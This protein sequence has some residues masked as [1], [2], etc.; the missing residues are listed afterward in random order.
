MTL[1]RS[2]LKCIAFQE[3]MKEPFSGGTFTSKASPRVTANH[4]LRQ[5][6]SFPALPPPHSALPPPGSLP[7]HSP[8]LWSPGPGPLLPPTMAT[9][10]PIRESF[11]VSWRLAPRTA[12]LFITSG[13]P[14]APIVSTGTGRSSTHVWLSNARF[15]PY[16]PLTLI[17]IIFFFFFFFLLHSRNYL[18]MYQCV[19]RC[20]PLSGV[21]C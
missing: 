11:V 3:I 7:P 12:A 6:P 2:I 15:R 19:C 1:A 4:H 16:L 13:G 21:E 20:V 14:L 8:G 10:C 17:I 18:W 5:H 9:G